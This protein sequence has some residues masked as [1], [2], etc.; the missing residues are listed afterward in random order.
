MGAAANQ[1][2]R[3]ASG[4]PR[5]LSRMRNSVGTAHR[6]KDPRACGR[7]LCHGRNTP[8]K[9]ATIRPK[10]LS[11]RGK[12]APSSA[13]WPSKGSPPVHATASDAAGSVVPCPLVG[14]VTTTD[15]LERIGRGRRAARR[16]GQAVGLE[17]P[18]PA[19]QERRRSQALRRALSRH[20]RA[21]TRPASPAFSL[22][23][24]A[25]LKFPTGRSPGPRP[26]PT[27]RC[28]PAARRPASGRSGARRRT[29]PAGTRGSSGSARSVSGR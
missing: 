4:S 22:S 1:T 26:A 27:R 23:P 28:A 14:I 5:R 24:A 2:K 11:G 25:D 9:A 17:G 20:A 21:G 18:R 3:G 19:P 16:Q 12:G 8:G 10:G 6:G 29:G 13:A 15:L 7:D